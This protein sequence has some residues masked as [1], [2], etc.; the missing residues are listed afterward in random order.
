MPFQHYWLVC[1][2]SFPESF[3]WF[4]SS[5]SVTASSPSSSSTPSTRHCPAFSP[6]PAR[7]SFSW[8]CSMKSTS[9]NVLKKYQ[10][11]EVTV[12]AKCESWLGSVWPDRAIYWTLGKFLKPVATISLPK[13]PTLRGNFC[14]GIKIFNFPSEI[15]FGQ[16]L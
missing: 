16:L 4:A 12:R 3:T 13:S 11:F 7:P 10:N 15:I 6:A 1:L 5:A 9:K 8:D 14:K 2:C